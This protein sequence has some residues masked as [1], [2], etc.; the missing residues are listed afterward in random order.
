MPR[1]ISA[2]EAAA[3]LTASGI[4]NQD[5]YTKGT[6]GKGSAWA[7]ATGRAEANY[8]SGVQA[9]IAAKR[10]SRG[11]TEAGPSAYDTGVQQKG[12]VN[13]PTGMQ[14]AG[15]K[16][17]RKVAKFQALWDQ[18]LPTPK[19]GRRSPNSMKRIQENI[20]RMVRVAGA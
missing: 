3:R 12:S 15:D 19:G 17:Q 13:W 7:G 10:F 9:A 16:Y 6:S 5:R 11:V 2:A 20:D 14:Q 8:N 1:N 18:A 4:N